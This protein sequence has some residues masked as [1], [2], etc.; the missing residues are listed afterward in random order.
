M[1]L[2]N[3]FSSLKIIMK[4]RKDEKVKYL[5]K[6][7]IK[8]AYSNVIINTLFLLVQYIYTELKKNDNDQIILRVMQC[9]YFNRLTPYL[10]SEYYERS[11]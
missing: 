3:K 1:T 11:C 8:Y 9:T 10:Y 4:R 6:F 5:F 2:K 7:L